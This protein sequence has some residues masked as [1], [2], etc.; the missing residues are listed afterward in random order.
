MAE[1]ISPEELPRWVPG[2]VTLASDGLGW[3]EVKLRA[4]QYA[5]SDVAV[6]GLSDFMLVAY[7]EGQTEMDRRVDGPWTHEQMVPG[8]VSLLTRAE[9]S[10]WHWTSD[11]D[12]THLY[13]TGD[14][15]GKVSA[16]MFDRD[17]ADVRLLD[18]LKTD[19]PILMRGINA[20]SEEARNCDLGGALFV[21]AIATQI[22]VQILRRYSTVKFRE[23]R[24]NAGLSPQQ[25]R[26][27]VDY[28]EA[29]LDRALTLEELSAIARVSSSHFLRQFKLRFGSAP[30][31]Y[32]IQRRLAFVQSLLL[33]ST[34]PL[35]EIAAKGG[36]SDQSH[37]TRVFQ[38]YLRTTPNAYR[39]G[40]RDS[41][42]QFPS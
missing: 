27:I 14:L 17:I 18:M 19:D 41:T 21:D 35:K 32:V 3:R 10:H 29:N 4:Y 39:T 9:A 37:M 15:L 36:F 24:S 28:I 5:P 34:L 22:C 16:E 31:C 7:R 25:A 33:K 42:Q 13:I 1:L 12:V 8:N 30:H 6:P 38:R 11:I 40:L 26:A 2:K 20:I 23:Q